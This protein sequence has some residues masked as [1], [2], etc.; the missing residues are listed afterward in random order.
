[1][2]SKKMVSS[3]QDVRNNT[4]ADIGSDHYIVVVAMKVQLK[5]AA[6][7][8]KHTMAKLKKEQMISSV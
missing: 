1:M 4:G 5:S 6:K 7:R 2:L 8:M 3:F